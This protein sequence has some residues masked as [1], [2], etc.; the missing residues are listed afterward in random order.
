M[1]AFAIYFVEKLNV[2]ELYERIVE[3]EKVAEIP[4]YIQRL[5]NTSEKE[6]EINKIS[7]S[8]FDPY[9]WD[10]IHMPVRGNRCQHGQCFDL[11]TFLS[12][13]LAAR[14]RNWKCPVC[15]K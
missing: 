1:F 3:E 11:K 14:N 10:L 12:F 4:N 15:N 13:M 8:I 6:I 9:T 5:M 2:D 7:V